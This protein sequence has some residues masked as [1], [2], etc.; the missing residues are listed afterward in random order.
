MQ[1][2]WQ[3]FQHPPTHAESSQFSG[4]VFRLG[5]SPPKTVSRSQLPLLLSKVNLEEFIKL[6]TVNYN[7]K[8]NKSVQG[9]FSVDGKELR[10]SIPT[11][12]KRGDCIVQIVRHRNREVVGQGFYNGQKE[13]EVPAIKKLLEQTKIKH[14]KVSLDALHLKP[15]TL[16]L[17]DESK[18]KYLVGLKRN[19]KKLL[20]KMRRSIWDLPELH[21]KSTYEKGH[22]RY[23]QRNYT[24]Y[25]IS[26]V[27]IDQRWENV[28]F[29]TLIQV[30]RK[31]K[32]L[33]TNKQTEEVAYYISNIVTRNI[34]IA[35]ELFD[36]VRKHWQIEVN[37][38]IRDCILKEDKLCT[39][40]S[41]TTKTIACCRTL[42][43]RLLDAMKVRNKAAQLDLFADKFHCCLDELKAIKFL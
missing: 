12:S 1:P 5:N 29:Q 25:N 32:V 8:M 39:S 3:S 19:Q 33:K 7:F 36:A 20:K 13:S 28:N 24:C 43:M 22:G 41:F 37:N 30:H 18:G 4:G 40:N 16:K 2:R 6:T 15:N 17:I 31:R 14:Q 23:E 26:S 10:G 9:W 34:E 11:G 38:N 42:T 21:H 27:A 35:E